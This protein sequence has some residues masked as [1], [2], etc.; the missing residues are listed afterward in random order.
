MTNKDKIIDE[1][2]YQIK[3][4]LFFEDTTALAELL[5]MLPIEKLQ[6]YLPEVVE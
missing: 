1:V 6:N 5:A 3:M 4:D 2:I